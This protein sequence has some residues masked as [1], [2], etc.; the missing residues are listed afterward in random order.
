MCVYVCVLTVNWLQNT[1]KVVFG[2]VKKKEKEEKDKLWQTKT[3][4]DTVL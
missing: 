1:Q 2:S 4:Y 3:K